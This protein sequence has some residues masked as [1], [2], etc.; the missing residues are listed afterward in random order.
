MNF[1]VKQVNAG[2]AASDTDGS[3]A[4]KKG[5]R[6]SLH[7]VPWSLREYQKQFR[8]MGRHRYPQKRDHELRKLDSSDSVGFRE[9]RRK[10]ETLPGVSLF[11]SA[12]AGN[13]SVQLCTG[14]P[15]DKM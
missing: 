4:V 6:A 12:A 14:L 13:T 7:C 8:K 3:A 2:C 15:F 11:E 9:S 1:A 5:K 10:A